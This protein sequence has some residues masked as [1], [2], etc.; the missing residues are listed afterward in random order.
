[1]LPGDAGAGAEPTY[2]SISRSAIPGLELSRVARERLF[3]PYPR[4]MAKPTTRRRGGTGL[5]GDLR[6]LGR[7]SWLSEIG[8]GTVEGQGSTFYWFRVALGRSDRLPDR[9]LPIVR[10]PGRRRMMVTHRG[11]TSR[12]RVPDAYLH[13]C[14]RSDAAPIPIYAPTIL[15]AEDNP[16][17][18]EVALSF[19]CGNLG[20]AGGGGERLEGSRS[21]AGALVCPSAY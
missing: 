12:T 16:V 5:G 10:K 15:V 7:G 2:S 4:R 14:R 11:G 13:R 1:V 19:N 6:R 18:R 20:I 21:C 8:V 9:V 17:N 3:K